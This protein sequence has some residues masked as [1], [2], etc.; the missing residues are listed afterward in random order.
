MSNEIPIIPS[1]MK[2]IS[3]Q[4]PTL[5]LELSDDQNYCNIRHGARFLGQVTLIY[6][7]QEAKQGLQY[8]WYNNLWDFIENHTGAR[9]YRNV[10]SIVDPVS[11]T[12]ILKT[13]QSLRDK[14]GVK[15]HQIFKSLNGVLHPA[16]DVL[17]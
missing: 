15:W 1:L 10:Y 4:D 14:T 9:Y 17:S 2:W 16:E 11:F 7:G 3:E 6:P 5:D 13:A 12:E 8:D